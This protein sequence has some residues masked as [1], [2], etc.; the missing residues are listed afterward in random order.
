MPYKKA[1]ANWILQKI[2]SNCLWGKRNR[3]HPAAFAFVQAYLLEAHAALLSTTETSTSPRPNTDGW[4]TLTGA[5][6]CSVPLK[7]NKK[8]SP[9][10]LIYSLGQMFSCGFDFGFHPLSPPDF[11]RC[12]G[13]RHGT[14]PSLRRAFQLPHAGNAEHLKSQS[15]CVDPQKDPC[16]HTGCCQDQALQEEG[17]NYPCATAPL[18][19][20]SKV[21]SPPCSLTYVTAL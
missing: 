6:V 5:S 3:Q 19:G 10:Y 14:H 18:L 12:F 4:G 17:V 7:K 15:R 16:A 20:R 9:Q 11:R 21:H 8:K 1:V 2:L 13:L